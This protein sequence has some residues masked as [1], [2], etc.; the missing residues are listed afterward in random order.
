VR[1]PS[2]LRQVGGAGDRATL[3]RGV[4][5]Y[6]HFQHEMAPAADLD[7]AARAYHAAVMKRQGV[8]PCRGT[9]GA[10]FQ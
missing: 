8:L 5:A 9:T 3:V 2:R 7:P 6:H 10:R 1:A 4:D